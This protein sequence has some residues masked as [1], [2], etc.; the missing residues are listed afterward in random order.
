MLERGARRTLRCLLGI[1]AVMAAVDAGAAE[2]P[3]EGIAIQPISTGRAD[4]YFQHFVVQ[5]GLEELGYEIKPYLEAQFPAL[6]LALGQGDADYTAVHWNPLH[7]AFFENAG[8][9]AVMERVGHLITGAVQGYLI[10]KRTAEDKGI[11]NLDQFKDPAVAALFDSNG[12]GKADLVGCNPGWG[13]EAVIEHQLDV[14]ELRD[15]VVHN[16]GEYFALIAD[17]ITRY[18]QGQPIFYYTWT[19][20]WVGSVLQPGRDSV[21]LDVPFSAVP[22]DPGADTAQPDGHNTGFKVNTIG[23]LANKEFLAANPP[24]RRFLELVEIPLDDVNAA[25]LKQHEGETSLEQIRGH[26][27][28]WVADHRQ[29][30]DAWIAEAAQAQ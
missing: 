28:A 3:G 10:D 8:G 29:Q 6:H 18:E 2:R 4:H 26:A 23:V 14:F 24:A 7:D 11:T 30:F 21:W 16:Q 12:D 1:A 27:E 5:I 19:P 17:A 15:S 25:I 13:C 9:D 20:L 22:D